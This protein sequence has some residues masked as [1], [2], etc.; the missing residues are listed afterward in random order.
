M[1]RTRVLSTGFF[2]AALAL[3]GC[4]REERTPVGRLLG[5]WVSESGETHYYFGPGTMCM[6]D[7]GR[8]MQQ[9]YEVLEWDTGGRWI[10]VRVR[11]PYGTGHDKHLVFGPGH[12][13]IRSTIKPFGPH[14]FSTETV[15]RY[16][17]EKRTP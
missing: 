2:L 16:V 6:V 12:K 7:Q 10:R 15:W 8:A 9:R 1:R 3:A 5:H 4:A 11:T 13:T 14:A 17:D